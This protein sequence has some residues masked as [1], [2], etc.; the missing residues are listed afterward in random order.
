VELRAKRYRLQD[1]SSTFH[2]R[3]IFAPAA[4]HL[5]LGAPLKAFGPALHSIEKDDPGEAQEDGGKLRGSIMYVDGFGNLVSNIGASIFQLFQTSFPSHTLFVTIDDGSPI[6]LYDTYGDAPE[7]G[8]TALFG[9]FRMLEIAVREGRAA[10]RLAVGPG[11][12]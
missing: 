8:L 3:D 12:T 9:S 4:A 1:V 10:D 6:E 5:W 11:A 2:G 7:G